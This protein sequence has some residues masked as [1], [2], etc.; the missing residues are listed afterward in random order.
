MFKLDQ[1]VFVKFIKD[2]FIYILIY[3]DNL[4][5]TSLSKKLIVYF[6]IEFVKYFD[7]IDKG[8][9]KWF[10][11]ID[12]IYYLEEIYLFQEDYVVKTLVK[13][14]FIELNSVS[15]S[16]NEK[17]VLVANLF[18]VLVSNIDVKQFQ[19][20]IGTFIQL[21]V[22]TR[23]DISFLVIKLAYFLMNLGEQYWIT[24]KRVFCYLQRLK[25]L[26]IFF[27]NKQYYLAYSLVI[28]NAEN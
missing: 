23:P 27:I 9:I 1:S 4:F 21:I 16:M 26:Y 3:V 8:E 18:E 20:Q 17:L 12:I 28:Y 24:L 5:I 7:L 11:R 19:E 22:S 10:L 2:G 6:K 13:F 14:G 25:D 15:T